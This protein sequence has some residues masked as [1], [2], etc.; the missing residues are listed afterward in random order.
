MLG[1]PEGAKSSPSKF[2]A[3][4]NAEAIDGTDWKVAWRTADL[5]EVKER[6]G[7]NGTF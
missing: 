1:R 3:G 6:P 4:A 7:T 2:F 5:N